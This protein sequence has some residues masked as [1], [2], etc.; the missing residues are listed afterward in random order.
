M[1]HKQ[2]DIILIPVPF[3]NLKSKKKRPALI[4]SNE[5]HNNASQDI[6]FVAITSN[7]R[8]GT[9]E[10][11]FNDEDMVEGSIPHTSCVRCDKVFALASEIIVKKYG[12]LSDS[13]LEKVIEGL[14]E[15]IT[16]EKTND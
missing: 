3:T 7:I 4:I 16:I 1:M 5:S 14:E 13:K 9:N 15:I 2:G 12:K 11:I 8:G 10:I 6:I